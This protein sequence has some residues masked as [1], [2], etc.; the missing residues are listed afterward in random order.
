MAL[1]D[2]RALITLNLWTDITKYKIRRAYKT[3]KRFVKKLLEPRQYKN[4]STTPFSRKKFLFW[5]CRSFSSPT[6][7][8]KKSGNF[9]IGFFWTEWNRSYNVLALDQ[10]A[11]AKSVRLKALDCD[12]ARGERRKNPWSYVKHI[13]RVINVAHNALNNS[14]K[15]VMFFIFD[16]IR[17]S[18]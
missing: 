15:M 5:N 17:L 2:P 10:C 16:P 9:K 12:E 13:E 8:G 11:F 4:D 3:C 6:W 7:R 1:R 14:E 18:W